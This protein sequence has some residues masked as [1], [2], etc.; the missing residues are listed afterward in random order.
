MIIEN[1]FYSCRN[2]SEDVQTEDDDDEEGTKVTTATHD[3]RDD[4]DSVED[5]D[6]DET[7]DM[8]D[9]DTEDEQHQPLLLTHHQLM[10]Q[11]LHTVSHCTQH[12]SSSLSS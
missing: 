1:E 4:Y 7:N 12:G 2:I 8:D 6:D 9:T 3:D 10:Q 11:P 5:E